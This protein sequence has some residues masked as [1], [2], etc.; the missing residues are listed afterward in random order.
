[1]QHDA[2][3]DLP[4]ITNNEDVRYLGRV[5]GDVIRAFGG[6]RL[7]TATEAIRAASV[8]RH[9]RGGAPVDHHLGKLSL[10]ETL[11]F[12][13]GFM[14]FSMLANLAE[15]RQGIAAEQ[16]ADV[17]S[18]L[19][20]L[21][22]EGI[23]KEAVKIQI[24][25]AWTHTALIN[26][27]TVL[28]AATDPDRTLPTA[29]VVGRR[30][31]LRIAFDHA[32]WDFG[33]GTTDTTTDPGQPYSKADPCTT[34]QCAQYYGH[35]YRSTGPATITLTVAWHA[36]FSLDNGATWTAVDTVP[37]TG[38]ETTHQL[39]VAQARGVLVPDPVTH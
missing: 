35:T 29:T 15:D 31:Q 13:R 27:E 11:D 34:A 30:V 4:A 14:L 28:W 8:E 23:D 17:A 36:E 20:R 32:N 16:G 38:P 21:A 22:D 2:M 33:D 18:A 12:V 19:E 25:S 1:M 37:L 5:L 24:G 3:A 26:A 39:D 6:E 10:D 9:R 7:F